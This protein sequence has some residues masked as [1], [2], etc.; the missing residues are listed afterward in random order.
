VV[1]VIAGLDRLGRANW[2][3][4]GLRRGGEGGLA[5]A[6]SGERQ[7]SRGSEAE[8]ESACSCF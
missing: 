1:R 7:Q 4:R 2:G 8:E 3:R 5:G 6:A